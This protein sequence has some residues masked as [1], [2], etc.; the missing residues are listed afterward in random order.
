M[1]KTTV[2]QRQT[3]FMFPLWRSATILM[4]LLG[5][6]PPLSTAAK[7]QAVLSEGDAVVTGFSGIK[8]LDAPVPPGANPL[9]TFF[10]D[11]DGPSMQ[12]V[13]LGAAGA[14]PQGQLI[15][16][17]VPFK[18]R[19][20]DIGQVFAIALDDARP[21][22][23]YLGATS[24][25]GIQIVAPG[26]DGR[27]RRIKR[28][29]PIADWMPGQSA[30][31]IGGGPGS[32]YKVDGG[33][34]AV[35]LFATIPNNSGPGL[36]DIVHD[37][38][39]RHFYVSD[40]DTGLVHRLRADGTVIDSFDHGVIGR[41]ARGLPPVAD[42]G[43]AMNI[44]SPAFHS[45]DPSTWGYTSDDRLVWGLA[46]RGGRLYY[47]VGPQVW[48]VGLK[49][50]GGFADDARWE[51]EVAGMETGNVISD[52]AFD[53]EGRLYLA[54]RGR[55]RGSYDYT[56][57]A[58][59]KQSAVLRYQ[60]DPAKP[61]T[62]ARVPDEYAIGMP[63]D[64]RNAS[65]GVALGYGYDAN[66]TIRRGACD[67]MLWSTGD[68]LRSSTTQSLQTVSTGQPNGADVHGLQGNSRD[69]VRPQNTPPAMSYFI[70]Y[71]GEFA[72][73]EKAGH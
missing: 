12:I 39:S 11:L 72:D 62:W 41:P 20:G 28:G 67:A 26:H 64:H 31:G 3:N 35:S 46:I 13:Q 6:V 66:G 4:L 69:L 49:V 14:A 16:A 55:V 51:F 17:P 37:R 61:G 54:Q 47:A 22:N 19:A 73:P 40:L 44:K 71:D 34:G 59:A 18:V 70:D 2:A 5:A 23:I 38:R 24:A 52:I 36:G 32:I 43:V 27:P 29:L 10:I 42:A 1:C 9:D 53:A 25:F 56:V 50:D 15:T 30:S 21:P 60:R 63:R 7:A 65:G 45:E 58:E 48:S 68:R 57:F 33:T 8:P